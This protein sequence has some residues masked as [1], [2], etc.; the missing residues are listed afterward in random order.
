MSGHHSRDRLLANVSKPKGSFWRLSKFASGLLLGRQAEPTA[1]QYEEFV[2]LMFEV[3]T[4]EEADDPLK[5]LEHSRRAQPE[6]SGVCY[7]EVG[8]SDSIS[9]N[10]IHNCAHLR[11]D[12]P[13]Y[14]K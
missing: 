4:C 14:R 7:V 13:E 8:H 3:P 10:D 5:V 9:A 12:S 2:D 1:R 6:G 11:R